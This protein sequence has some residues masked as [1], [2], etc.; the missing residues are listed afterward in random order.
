VRVRYEAGEAGTQDLNADGNAGSKPCAEMKAGRHVSIGHAVAETVSSLSI[1][2][3]DEGVERVSCSAAR[4]RTLRPPGASG[5]RQ[6]DSAT[7]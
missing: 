2:T 1:V 4:T 3:T 7:V 5:S 6:V